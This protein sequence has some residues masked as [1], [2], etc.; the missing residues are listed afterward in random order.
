VGTS[1]VGRVIAARCAETGKR[2]QA[3]GSAKNHLV[4]MRDAKMDEMIRNM[5]TSCYGCAGQRCMAS[6]A[7]VGV[8]D[9]CYREVCRQFVET[10][11]Q[12]R[13]ADPLDPQVADEAMVMG[14]V[15]SAKAKAFILDMIQTGIDE[16]A[17]LALDG[18]EL[19]VPGCEKGHFLGPTVFT[20]VKPGMKIHQTEIFGPVVVILKADSL[21]E[22]IRIL[23]E[24]QYSNGASIYTQNGYYA[25]KFKLQTDAGMIGINVGIP[26][27]VAPLPFGGM[28]A[29]MLADTKAQGKAVIE[30]FT[31]RKI[32]TERY[33]PEG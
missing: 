16:G 14:P 8:G 3:L 2:F 7:I 15:I 32:I 1:R 17:T 6:S 19:T 23:N 28:K 4:A 21:D 12:V 22:A 11:K 24:H 31:E 27:P 29:S 33:W 9:D 13:V 25:R 5:V 18:R 20:D 10:S 26:A 30:F